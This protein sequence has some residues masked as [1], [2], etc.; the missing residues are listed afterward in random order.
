[1]N[2]AVVPFS[3]ALRVA[4]EFAISSARPKCIPWDSLVEGE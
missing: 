2:E 1:M 4:Q 3:E